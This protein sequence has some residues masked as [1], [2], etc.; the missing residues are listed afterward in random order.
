MFSNCGVEVADNAFAS[1][2][3]AR[4]PQSY[5]LSSRKKNHNKRT[6]HAHHAQGKIRQAAILGSWNIWT[7]VLKHPLWSIN[8]TI[9]RGLW[10]L[11]AVPVWCSGSDF[12]QSLTQ[13]LLSRT[14]LF[15][16]QLLPIA[17]PDRRAADCTPLL[18]RP[19]HLFDNAQEIPPRGKDK[20]ASPPWRCVPNV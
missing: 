7:G 10:W 3:G 2:T 6:E 17:S 20:F 1:L 16:Y 5:K 19:M 12:C 4:R 14:R 15:L 8:V 18:R 13:S 11:E 9:S